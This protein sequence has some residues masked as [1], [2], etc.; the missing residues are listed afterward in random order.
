MN[1]RSQLIAAA[2][3]LAVAGGA[4]AYYF[5][6]Y[7]QQKRA[8]SRVLSTLTQ[9]AKTDDQKA[10]ASALEAALAEDARL[11]LNVTLEMMGSSSQLL[12]QTFSKQEFIRFIDLTLYST[13]SHH[14]SVRME[15]MEAAEN[16]RITSQTVGNVVAEAMDHREG[17][18]QRVGYILRH[19]CK[20]TFSSNAPVAPQLST[21]ECAVRLRY[22]LL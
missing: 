21:A 4:S 18:P 15:H 11:T 12:R 10:V 8:V 20:L 19:E 22:G 13:E 14:F 16:N 1:R 7:Q 2:L 3:L 5:S 6:P 9:A 17:K